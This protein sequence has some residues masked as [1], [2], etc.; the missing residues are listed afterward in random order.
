[1]HTT[2]R[3]G[4]RGMALTT[5]GAIMGFAAGMVKR[6]QE[7]YQAAH[8]KAKTPA[9]RDALQELLK[10]EGKNHS[11]MEMTRREHVTEMILEPVTGLRQEDYE[12]EVAVPQQAN[13]AEWVKVALLVEERERKFFSDCSAKIPLPEVARIFNKVA[14]KKE[15][16]LAKLRN[17]T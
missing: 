12:V 13:D 17:L 8:E 10:E 15:S 6:G 2:L 1:M 9:L 14:R 11:L 7:V 3:K 5:F 16:N 4:K